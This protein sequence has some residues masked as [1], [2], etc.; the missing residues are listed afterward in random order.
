[1]EFAYTLFVKLVLQERSALKCIVRRESAHVCEMED[2]RKKK[3]Y[4]QSV[5]EIESGAYSLHGIGNIY[6]DIVR[7]IVQ[8]A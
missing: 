5:S 6:N 7:N 8:L 2:E 3:I 4:I 1:M